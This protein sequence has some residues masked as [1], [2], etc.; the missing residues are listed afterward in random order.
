MSHTR[1]IRNDKYFTWTG[2]ASIVTWLPHPIHG[3]LNV[4][5]NTRSFICNIY[6][7]ALVFNGSF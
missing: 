6:V 2:P 5:K 4:G 3:E 1:N 7:N